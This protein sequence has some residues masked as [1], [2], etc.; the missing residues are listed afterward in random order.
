MVFVLKY[1]IK[2]KMYKLKDKKDKVNKQKTLLWED[3]Y[4]KKERSSSC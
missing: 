4:P 3:I 1:I 2:V